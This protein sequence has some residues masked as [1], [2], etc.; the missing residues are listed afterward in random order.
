MYTS[1]NMPD[2]PASIRCGRRG[3]CVPVALYCLP[4]LVEGRDSIVE[5]WVSFGSSGNQQHTWMHVDGVIFDPTIIQFRRFKEFSAGARYDSILIMPPSQYRDQWLSQ[6]SPWWRYR[7]QLFGV[8]STSW[9]F[10]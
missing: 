2:I 4:Q 1:A 3:S 9:A 5:G 6:K 8:P 10:A 7:L